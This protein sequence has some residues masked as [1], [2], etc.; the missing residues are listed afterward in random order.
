[1]VAPVRPVVFVG[2]RLLDGRSADAITGET[3]RIS[4][5]R[6]AFSLKPVSFRLVWVR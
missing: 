4:R 3:V 2:A 5:G 1:M 6:A